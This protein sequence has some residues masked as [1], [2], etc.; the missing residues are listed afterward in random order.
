MKLHLFFVYLFT[1]FIFSIFGLIATLDIATPGKLESKDVQILSSTKMAVGNFLKRF[2][3]SFASTF[4]SHVF[5]CHASLLNLFL[6]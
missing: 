4:S 3:V 6:R 5:L 1:L 2:D